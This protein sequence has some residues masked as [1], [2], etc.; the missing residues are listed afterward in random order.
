MVLAVA[1]AFDA[2]LSDRPYRP[3]LLPPEVLGVLR[4]GA[5]TQWDPLVVACCLACQKSLHALRAEPAVAPGAI[6]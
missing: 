6:G 1:D 3:A 5:G 4:A 2:M